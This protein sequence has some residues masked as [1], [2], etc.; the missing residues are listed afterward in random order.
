MLVMDGLSAADKG[1]LDLLQTMGCY[2]VRLIRPPPQTRREGSP[3]T[4]DRIRK[5]P[6]GRR[7]EI[8]RQRK[9]RRGFHV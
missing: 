6:S 2:Q 3:S 4:L 9:A 5:C 8:E 1:T 7:H